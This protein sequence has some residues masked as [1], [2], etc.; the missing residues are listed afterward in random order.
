MRRIL[1]LIAVTIAL[2]ALAA[3]PIKM[4]TSLNAGQEVPGPGKGSGSADLSFDTDKGKICY[5]IMA[6]GTDTPTM[7][8]IH[9]GIIG[10]AGPVVVPLKAPETGTV[11]A[12]A[13]VAPDLMAAILATPSDYYVNVHTEAYPKGAIRGQLSK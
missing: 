3:E 8:H 7:A 11:Q 10:V 9:K 5:M 2:P 1:T 12:C 4:S 6:Q 13:T